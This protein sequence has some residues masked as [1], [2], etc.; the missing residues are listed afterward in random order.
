MLNLK[1]G[2]TIVFDIIDKGTVV[3]QK[4]KKF[5]KEYLEMVYK[6]LNEWD[7]KEDDE[8]YEHLQNL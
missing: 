5:D 4:A 8:A 2:D 6:M 3:M 7:S 1:A